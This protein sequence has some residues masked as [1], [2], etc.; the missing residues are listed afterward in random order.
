MFPIS[1]LTMRRSR[2]GNMF[3]LLRRGTENIA[4]AGG[5]LSLMPTG[6]FQPASITPTHDSADF[7]LWRNIMREYS[8]EFLGNPEH[9]G[10]AIDYENEGPF[11]SLNAARCEGRIKAY[12]LGVG[13]DALNS[14]GAA[15]IVAV[16]DAGTFDDV[17]RAMVEINEESAIARDG[18][19]LENMSLT[20]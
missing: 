18:N 4:I 17:F 10:D 11:R 8:E 2:T 12:C 5:M 7:D 3:V 20:T 1:T 9:D 16:F 19:S 6:V 15:L 13:R 14:V